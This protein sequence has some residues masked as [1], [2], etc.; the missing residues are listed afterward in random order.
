M[1]L[2]IIMIYI[3]ITN[4]LLISQFEKNHSMIE[5]RHLKNVVIFS[6]TILNFVLSRKIEVELN[7]SNYAT[8]S[9]LKKATGLDTSQFAKKDDLAN[10]KSDIDELDIDEL[11]QLLSSLNSLKSKVDK[12]D[13]DRLKPVPTDLSKLGDVV[14]NDVVKKTEYDELNKK[15]SDIDTSKLVNKTNYDPKIKDI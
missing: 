12:L 14:K 2:A 3:N 10:L 1:S 7:L 5:P 4:F 9:V 6:Q 11:K 15:I 8:K 13:V